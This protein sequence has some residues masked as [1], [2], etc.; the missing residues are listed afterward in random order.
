[1]TP[2]AGLYV[3]TDQHLDELTYMIELSIPGSIPIFF[4]KA[5][6]SATLII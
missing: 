1:M 5:K 4:P 3:S 6:A 2:G